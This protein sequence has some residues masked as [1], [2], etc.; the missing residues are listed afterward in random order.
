MGSSWN[1]PAPAEPSYEGSKPSQAKLEHFI[2]WA[3][4]ELTNIEKNCDRL[5]CIAH[6]EF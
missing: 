2:F 1:F 6:K 5:K 4:A 3:E